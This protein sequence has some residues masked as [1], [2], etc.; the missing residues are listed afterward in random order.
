MR[1]VFLTALAATGLLV[2]YSS[3]FAQS[4][5]L[6]VYTGPPNDP[7]YNDRYDVRPDPR[8]YGY[9]RDNDEVI[10]GR[11]FVRPSNCGEFHY[12]DD[13]RCADARVDPPNIR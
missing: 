7:Y 13:T 4:V 1:R 6:E 3:A 11:V 8:V 2:G 5:G 10:G 9:Y 12:W